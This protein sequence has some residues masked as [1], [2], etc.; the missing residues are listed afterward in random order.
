[1]AFN[2]PLPPFGKVG[3]TRSRGGGGDLIFQAMLYALCAVPIFIVQRG[4]SSGLY[5]YGIQNI[6]AVNTLCL[7]FMFPSTLIY[8][9]IW[10]P[11]DINVPISFLYFAL[12]II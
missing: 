8:M 9:A 2:F 5:L 3:T 11:P 6:E 1:M 4:T 10:L 12:T 7:G